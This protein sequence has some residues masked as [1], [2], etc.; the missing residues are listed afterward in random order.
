M[1]ES[2]LQ[3]VPVFESET[4]G[5]RAYRIP[6][7]ETAVD[8]TLLTFAEAR[9]SN[10]ADPG[11]DGQ[12]IDL[13]MKY[14]TDSGTTW[15]EMRVIEA[16][17][18]LWSAANPA[19]VLDRDT[20]RVWLIYL[21][22]RPGATSSKAR[23]GTDDV[24]VLAR[25]SD[26]NGM[27][28]SEPVDLTAVSRDLDDDRW[29][30]TVPGPGG[31]I[32]ARDGRL[33]VPCWKLEP[34]QNFVIF[35]DDHGATWER[36]DFV[37]EGV[38]RGNENQ[39][40]ELTDGRILMDIRQGKGDHRW[41]AESADGGCTWSAPRPGITVTPVACAI[42]RLPI[43]HA[44]ETGGRIVWTGPLGP[45]RRDLAVRVSRDSARTF[46]APRLICKS[47]PAY[48]DLTLLPDGTVGV[49]W[50]HGIESPYETLTFTRLPN[51]FLG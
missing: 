10:L 25:S 32:Q 20:N 1:T 31:A 5:Y 37:P 29:H 21:R 34:W 46:E 33:I 14:S 44:G 4:D 28:W 22:C 2:V 9:K 3:H 11:G 51:R 12:T 39:T 15:S 41:F 6:A 42:E 24:R 47:M 17:G 7:I 19:T 38:I 16:P 48:S 45:D 43:D 35:S 18:L 26:D 13:V 23:P 40:V 8:G 36:G 27:T 49:L 50:E 30:C